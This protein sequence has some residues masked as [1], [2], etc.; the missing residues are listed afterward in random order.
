MNLKCGHSL[1]EF[2]SKVIIKITFDL[3]LLFELLMHI[4]LKLTQIRK[5]LVRYIKMSF[6]MILSEA[7]R[8]I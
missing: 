2:G 7:I 4:R 8:S 6:V 3:S 1:Q 5:L